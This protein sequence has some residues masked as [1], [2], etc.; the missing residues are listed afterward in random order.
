[1]IFKFESATVGVAALSLV[2]MIALTGCLGSAASTAASGGTSNY[3]VTCTSGNT[4][5]GFCIRA[6]NYPYPYYVGCSGTSG[7]GSCGSGWAYS[8]NTGT[9]ITTYASFAC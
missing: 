1:M 5:S 2:A 4:S 8:C 9:T 3:T 6:T 7:T